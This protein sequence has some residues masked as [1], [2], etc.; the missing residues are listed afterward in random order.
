M[1]RSA[2]DNEKIWHLAKNLK[3]KREF[4]QRIAR[5]TW[6]STKDHRKKKKKL[7]LTNDQLGKPFQEIHDKH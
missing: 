4:W 1:R 7:N 3:I 5:N 2:K 6:I